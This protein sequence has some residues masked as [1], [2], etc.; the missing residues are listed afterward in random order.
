MGKNSLKQYGIIDSGKSLHT[1]NG[2]A[3]LNTQ[4]RRPQKHNQRLT[5]AETFNSELATLQND[6]GVLGQ[7]AT[8]DQRGTPT[9]KSSSIFGLRSRPSLQKA[10]QRKLS[11]SKRS[12]FDST[13]SNRAH[14]FKVNGKL[15]KHLNTRSRTKQAGE[16]LAT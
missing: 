11:L 7:Q 6:S 1:C 13:A 3:S 14:S 12:D 16:V 9:E 15:R 8:V 4:G 2:G 10:L 5:Q